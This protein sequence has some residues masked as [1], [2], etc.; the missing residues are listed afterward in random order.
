MMNRKNLVISVILAVGL[1]GLLIAFINSQNSEN[2]QSTNT[3]PQQNTS[4]TS[5]NSTSAEQNTST[6]ATSG[7][8][9]EYDEAKLASADGKKILFFHAPWCPQCNNIE[10]GIEEQGV[11]AGVTIFKVDYDTSTELKQKYEVTLQ[12]TLV[13]IDGEGNL[14]TKHVAYSEPTFDAVKEAIL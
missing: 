13:V 14:V 9:I 2:E 4:T 6:A 12:S 8:Y 10:K 3:N 11:P 5:N 7:E 1:I